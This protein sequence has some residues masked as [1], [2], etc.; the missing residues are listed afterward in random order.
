MGRQIDHTD[1]LDARERVLGAVVS[2]QAEGVAQGHLHPNAAAALHGY[3]AS[4]ARSFQKNPKLLRGPELGFLGVP[5]SHE[6]AMCPESEALSVSIGAT[7]GHSDVGSS[8]R[9]SEYL[10]QEGLSLFVSVASNCQHMH[11]HTHK[12]G[13]HIVTLCS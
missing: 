2:L 13:V 12:F 9:R 1:V 10:Q 4:M 11:M 8:A 7:G 5:K 3:N 6:I